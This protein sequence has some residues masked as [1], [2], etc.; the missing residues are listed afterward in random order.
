MGTTSRQQPCGSKRSSRPHA[1][2]QTAVGCSSPQFG[3]DRLQHLLFVL[4]ALPVV[5]AV[6]VADFVA[7]VRNIL[8]QQHREDILLLAHHFLSELSQLYQEPVKILTPRAMELLE[9]YDWPGN[10][11]ELANVMQHVHALSSDRRVSEEDVPDSVRFA[12]VPLQDAPDNSVVPFDTAVR[13]LVK[14]AL[15]AADGSQAG[16]ARL[17][18]IDRGRLYRLVARLELREQV[19]RPSRTRSAGSAAGGADGKTSD[20]APK[21]LKPSEA[22]AMLGCG[23]AL[24]R[25]EVNRGNLPGYRVGPRGDIRIPLEA[26]EEYLASRTG[27]RGRPPG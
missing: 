25:R 10:V 13:S 6:G 17:L 5:V 11:R 22:A 21:V 16:A 12:I 24:V 3:Q 15:E 14:R 8:L 18:N 23:P 9:N 2:I 4:Q 26:V 20:S 27:R 7:Q 1:R 19:N